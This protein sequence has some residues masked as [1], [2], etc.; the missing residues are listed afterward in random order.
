[1]TAS[2]YRNDS[3][4]QRSVGH[5]RVRWLDVR[6]PVTIEEGQSALDLIATKIAGLE[7]QVLSVPGRALA[8]AYA[9]QKWEERRAEIEWWVVRMRAGE[10]VASME[11]AKER[12]AHA[13]TARRLDEA[14]RAPMT[15]KGRSMTAS[16]RAIVRGLRES[17]ANL[18]TAV[19]QR[20][21]AIERLKADKPAAPVLA[22]DAAAVK[23][24]YVARQHEIAASAL[25]CIDEIT[26]NGGA[27]TPVSAMIHTTMVQS[28]A[29]GYREKWR[30][31]H[32]PRIEDAAALAG[33]VEEVG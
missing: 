31:V 21:A 1:M 3:E 12:A 17:V 15:D 14:R 26:A 6:L 28:L 7:S 20:D 13:E 22:A 23:R 32:R 18:T 27:H 8:V 11:L 29:A 33:S 19:Q 24:A 4:T 5:D 9:T 10:S 16:E 30:I 2:V 25:E